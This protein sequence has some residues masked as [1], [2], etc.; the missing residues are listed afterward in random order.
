MW[1]PIIR[2]HVED[3]HIDNHVEP[4]GLTLHAG[5]RD[6]KTRTNNTDIVPTW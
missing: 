6:S 1:D 4:R 3:S 5:L 2:S